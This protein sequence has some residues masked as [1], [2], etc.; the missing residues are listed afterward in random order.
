MVVHSYNLNYLRCRGRKVI[1]QVWPRQK[2][3][4]LSEKQTKSKRTGIVPSG[5]MLP[6]KPK[7]LNSIPGTLKE[8]KEVWGY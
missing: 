2:Q 8:K 3:E 6:S 7:S 1:V 4:A 5:R